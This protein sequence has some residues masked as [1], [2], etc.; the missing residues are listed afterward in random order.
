L[1]EH[2]DRAE[3]RRRLPY[4]RSEHARVVVAGPAEA[5]RLEALQKRARERGAVTLAADASVTITVGDINVTVSGAGKDARE[6]GNEIGEHV[7]RRLER[8]GVLQTG[9]TQAFG[10]F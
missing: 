1:R 2:P 7:V 5:A 6:I 9:N 8:L 10:P 4:R 3:V